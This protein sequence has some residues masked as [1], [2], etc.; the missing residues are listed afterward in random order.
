[1]SS[2]HVRAYMDKV[3]IGDACTGH[4]DQDGA[5]EYRCLLLC[6]VLEH[7]GSAVTRV[8]DMCNHIELGHPNHLLINRPS[9]GHSNFSFLINPNAFSLDFF[10]CS[11]S[12]N[13]LS[14]D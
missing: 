9:L 12:S 4:V 5:A 13:Q 11:T 7:P 10:L 2:R 14:E 1:M 6:Q 8:G 3:L